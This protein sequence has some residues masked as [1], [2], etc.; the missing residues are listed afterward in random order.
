MNFVADE[1][2]DSPITHRLR[3]IGHIVFSIAEKLP[4]IDDDEVL[5]IANNSKSIY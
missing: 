1:S 4:G 2:L 5:K 3:E